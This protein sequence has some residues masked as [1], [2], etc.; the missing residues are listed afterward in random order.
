M[1]LS[2]SA[3]LSC[4]PPA[5]IP[6]ARRR[7]GP[8][9]NRGGARISSKST[10]ARPATTSRESPRPTARSDRRFDRLASRE[11][12]AGKLPNTPENLMRWI[13]DPQDVSPGT[14]MPQM[15][16]SEQ[17]GRDIAAF[18]YSLR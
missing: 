13:R 8:A 2:S 16:L 17:E 1:Q 14:A 3:W 9:A 11:Q 6:S 15:G 7:P 4:S 10:A 12:L 18:L 5:A